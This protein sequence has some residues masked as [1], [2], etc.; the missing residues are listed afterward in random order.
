MC[1]TVGMNEFLVAHTP[2]HKNQ[3]IE[4]CLQLTLTYSYGSKSP[5]LAQLN[6]LHLFYLQ[7]EKGIYNLQKKGTKEIWGQEYP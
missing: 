3:P 7:V 4:L 6:Y 5:N 1:Q 2:T